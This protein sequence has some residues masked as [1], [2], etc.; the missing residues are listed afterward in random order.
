MSDAAAIPL[1]VVACAV[2]PGGLVGQ[3]ARVEIQR[4]DERQAPAPLP[5]GPSN[6]Q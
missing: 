3:E 1:T 2:V 5:G 6:T 4:H